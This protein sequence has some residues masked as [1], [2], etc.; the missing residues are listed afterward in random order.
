MATQEEDVLAYHPSY[1]SLCRLGEGTFGTVYMA[2]KR[3]ANERGE[4]TVV[5]VKLV[6]GG[7]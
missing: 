7:R 2:R 1:E 4:R 5:A 6:K 3:Q